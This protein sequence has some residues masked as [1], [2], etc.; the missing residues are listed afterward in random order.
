MHGCSY[1]LGSF[2]K[3]RGSNAPPGYFL[4]SESDSL[5]LSASDPAMATNSCDMAYSLD[6][7]LSR[8][9]L[10]LHFK[11]LEALTHHSD[12]GVDVKR[13]WNSQVG[14]LA[15]IDS[16]H[17]SSV[18]F[19]LEVITFLI[20]RLCLLSSMSYDPSFWAQAVPACSYASKSCMKVL[21]IIIL[22]VCTARKPYWVQ[23]A[24]P[25]WCIIPVAL[26]CELNSN[27]SS[28]S[29]HCPSAMNE[30]TFPESVKTAW[31]VSQTCKDQ[32]DAFPCIPNRPLSGMPG[33]SRDSWLSEVKAEKSKLDL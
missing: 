21:L 4:F 31:C 24:H 11:N 13:Q 9:R 25:E 19:C 6:A 15:P 23:Q 2:V 22:Q 5:F 32:N 26:S 10:G 20:C 28:S 1:T 33:D 14:G 18:N 29:C 12:E 30:L 8:S 27:N 3:P 16:L 17:E 7:A